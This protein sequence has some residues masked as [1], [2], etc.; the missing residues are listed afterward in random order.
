M[1]ALSPAFTA[2]G[3]LVAGVTDFDLAAAR[4]SVSLHDLPVQCPSRWKDQHRARPQF[5]ARPA[6]LSPVLPR[7]YRFSAPV[8]QVQ[9]SFLPLV[10]PPPF[11][12]PSLPLSAFLLLVA[13]PSSASL[14]SF[15]LLLW[16]LAFPLFLP[17]LFSSPLLW[18][19]PRLHHRRRQSYR[20]RLPCR[21]LGHKSRCGFR[22]WAIPITSS[23]CR[24]QYRRPIRRPRWF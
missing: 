14:P 1:R 16:L 2:A 23:L 13:R 19:L 4:T 5:G 8:F 17:S 12:P 10:G 9:L 24:T 6:T 22:H 7:P 21:P 15:L 20:P 18:V 3:T 11:S